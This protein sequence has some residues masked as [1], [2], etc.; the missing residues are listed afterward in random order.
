MKRSALGRIIPVTLFVMF[1]DTALAFG[2]APKP[3]RKP[4]TPSHPPL[5]QLLIKSDLPA[6]ISLDGEPLHNGDAAGANEILRRGVTL[7]EHIVEAVSVDGDD[8]WREVLMVDKVGQRAVLIELEALRTARLAKEEQARKAAGDAAAAARKE[9]AARAEG[10]QREAAERAEHERQEAARRSVEEAS[11]RLRSR[12]S[13]LERQGDAYEQEAASLLRQAEQA[14]RDAQRY[15]SQGNSVLAALSSTTATIGR[16]AA[17]N[18]QRQAQA[19]RTAAKQLER[20][21]AAL[22]Q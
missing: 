8:K 20:E 13:E 14:D 17:Q 2:Q 18:H 9:A 1:L 4:T 3:K 7:G 5:A 22:R 6:L 12:I 19:A 10:E 15:Q 11:A 21:L 16:Q